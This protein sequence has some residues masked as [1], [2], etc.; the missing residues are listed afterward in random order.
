METYCN[1]NSKHNVLASAAFVVVP[2][3]TFFPLT[4]YSIQFYYGTSLPNAV[5]GRPFAKR[6]C[7][8]AV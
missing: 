4:K 7:R 1:K 3:C 5:P 6:L 8:K 2:R